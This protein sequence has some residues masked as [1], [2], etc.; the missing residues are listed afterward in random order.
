[1]STSLS[2]EAVRDAIQP[3]WPDAEKGV[4]PEQVNKACTVLTN[5]LD[6]GNTSEIS[7][8]IRTSSRLLA[9]IV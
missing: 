6:K 4:P 3:N 7:L 5:Y 2:V 1:M 8:I 9:G